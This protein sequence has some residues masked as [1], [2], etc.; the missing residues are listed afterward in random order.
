M[1]KPMTGIRRS[2]SQLVSVH[3]TTP[4]AGPDRIL[5]R[6]L[7]VRT[8]V[9]PPS[10]VLHPPSIDPQ[11]AHRN[12]HELDGRPP[13]ALPL[14]VRPQRLVEAVEEAVDVL[15]QDG[16]KVG[17]AGG[18]DAAGDDLDAGGEGRRKGYLGEADVGGESAYERFVLCRVEVKVCH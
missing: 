7:K 11:I 13:A 14:D 18:G 3:P 6:P 9:S 17:V 1:S 2:S 8:S 4:P 5:R 10:D 16:S 12:A 15:A